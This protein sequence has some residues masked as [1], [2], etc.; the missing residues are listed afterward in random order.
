MTG[1]AALGRV[2]R[3]LLLGAHCDD[4]AIGCGGTVLQLCR[5]NPGMRVTALVL[6]GAGT[7]REAEERMALAALCAKA[8]LDVTV[9]DLLDGRVPAQWLRAK[10]ALEAV[11]P[12]CEPDLILA[13]SPHDAH[14]D[15]RAL[16]KLVPT[17]FRAHQAL[18]YEILKW[19]G[20]LAQPNLY[21]ALPEQVLADKLDI[22][23]RHYGSQR[24][25]TWFDDEAFR[26]LARVRGVQSG[27][28]YAEAFHAAKV[29]LRV[30]AS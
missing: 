10:E 7:D 11:R 6:S 3:L 28:R 18:G 30:G 2:D 25:R 26:G 12:W 23:H 27:E 5:A 1:P 22:L 8:E 20:D 9:L 24:G 4:I 15:H 13:P 16:A 14:Q 21:V 29:T 19:D 17:V